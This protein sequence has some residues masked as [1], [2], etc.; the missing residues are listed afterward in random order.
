MSNPKRTTMVSIDPSGNGTTGIFVAVVDVE[1]KKYVSGQH[2]SFR[3]HEQS[4]MFDWLK[5]FVVGNK[6]VVVMEDY[7]DRGITSDNSTKTLIERIRKQCEL[8]DPNFI[9]ILQQPSAKA[10]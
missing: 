3:H 10:M 7:R 9:F 8:W 4:E 2:R 1:G 5:P 6:P